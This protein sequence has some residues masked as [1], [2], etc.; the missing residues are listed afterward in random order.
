MKALQRA[1]TLRSTDA[2]VQKY[3]QQ[4]PDEEVWQNDTYQVHV[5][6]GVKLLNASGITMCHLSIKR[7]DR[8][9]VTDWREM[10]WIKNQLVG[11]ECEGVE[12]FPK[13]S[14]LVDGAN[15]Y[16]MWVFENEQY[17]FPFGFTERLVSEKSFF[18]ETQRKFPSSRRPADLDT[19]HQ[20]LEQQRQQ[21]LHDNNK[22]NNS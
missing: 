3:I 6:R 19:M 10:Q 16:H 9:A 8:R 14:R 17:T 5:T 11:E 21:V 4:H 15:Q 12:L 18:G 2:V 1:T 20:Q 13:E 22:D 7:L